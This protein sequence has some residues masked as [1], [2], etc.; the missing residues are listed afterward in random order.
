MRRESGKFFGQRMNGVGRQVESRESW[1]AEARWWQIPAGSHGEASY[2]EATIL[3][4]AAGAGK[5][6][7]V[8][9]GVRKWTHF[10]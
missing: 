2:Q 6:Q 4:E 8:Q 9:A 5:L 10:P 3:T 1:D 7:Q